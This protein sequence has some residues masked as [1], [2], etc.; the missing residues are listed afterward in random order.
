MGQYPEQGYG[1][2][3]GA[4][5]GECGERSCSG[6]RLTVLIARSE[7]GV[8]CAVSGEQVVSWQWNFG[9]IS[10]QNSLRWP[11]SIYCQR[12]ATSSLID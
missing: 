9:S 3:N 5:S 2:S 6:R 4:G 11:T 12:D 1:S 8:F 7:T 10:D